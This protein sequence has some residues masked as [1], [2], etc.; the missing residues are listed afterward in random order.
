VYDPLTK[1]RFRGDEEDQVKR[2]DLKYI[3]IK[4]L[5]QMP[6]FG[7]VWSVDENRNKQIRK[8]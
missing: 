8:R 3:V 5:K 4:E 2:P 1:N 6:T 7:F